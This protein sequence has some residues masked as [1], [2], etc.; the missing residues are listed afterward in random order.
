MEKGYIVFSD[1]H[2][3]EENMIRIREIEREIEALGL[4]SLGDLCPGITPYLYNSIISV[5]GNCDRYYE[6]NEIPFPPIS[7]TIQLFNK[8]ILLYHGHIEIDTAGFDI[9]LSGHTHV[10]S[11][12]KEG[13]TY[14]CNPGSVSLPRSSTPPSFGLLTPFSF[15]ILSLI[16]LTVIESRCFS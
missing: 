11:I 14:Y 6:Y 5:R 10:P 1:L 15:S 3:I 7:R 8:N 4:I 2:G 9:V 12:T 13:N 16:D